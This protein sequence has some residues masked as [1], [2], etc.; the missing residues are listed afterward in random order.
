MESK[1]DPAAK[2]FY[3][4]FK[5]E[6]EEGGGLA[7]EMEGPGVGWGNKGRR[8]PHSRFRKWM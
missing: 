2:Q 1:A 7:G 8:S 5:I 6:K 3:F 4:L